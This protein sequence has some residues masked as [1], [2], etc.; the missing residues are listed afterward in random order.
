MTGIHGSGSYSRQQ[1]EDYDG[2]Y[3]QPSNQQQQPPGR[4]PPQQYQQF[5]PQGYP[6]QGYY[7]PAA[8]PAPRKKRRVFMWVFFAIQA[9]FIIWLVTGLISTGHTAPS[10]AELLK[11]CKQFADLYKTHAQCMRNQSQLDSDAS[12]TGRGLGAALIVIIWLVADFFLGLGYG[13]YRLASRR[14]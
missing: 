6:P 14:R 9:L 10:T 5:P 11:E 4:Y 1:S 12:G 7:A 2:L 13:I 3:R 8:Q